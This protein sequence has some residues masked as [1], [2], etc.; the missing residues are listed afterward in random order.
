[1]AKQELEI[2]TMQDAK[3]ETPKEMAAPTADAVPERKVEQLNPIRMKEGQYERTV[4][5]ITAHENTFPDDLSAPEYWSHVA[6]KLRPWDRIEAR[7]NDGTWYAELLV[8]EA[9]RNW[10]RAQLL[11][12]TKLSTTDV[13]MSQVNSLSPY[14]IKYRGPH[15]QWSVIRKVDREVVH[16]G[17]A[18]QGGAV[19]WLNERMKAGG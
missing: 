12:V 6:T 3:T 1:M 19:N 11:N 15:S 7:A 17:E 2:P 5:V 16:D 14:E 10:A 9:G 18:T 13:A 8:L 4:W